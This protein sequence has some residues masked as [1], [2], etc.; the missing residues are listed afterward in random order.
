VYKSKF[1]NQKPNFHFIYENE[2]EKENAILFACQNAK[3]QCK[4]QNFSIFNGLNTEFL[5]PVSL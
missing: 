2:G 1:K 4:V 5:L 3:L